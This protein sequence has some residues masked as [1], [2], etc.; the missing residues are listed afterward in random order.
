FK[1][2]LE[3]H[4]RT[5][6]ELRAIAADYPGEEDW[7]QLKRSIS[8]ILSHAPTPGK[9]PSSG[10]WRVIVLP[11]SSDFNPL[12]QR[13]LSYLVTLLIPQHPNEQQ[14]LISKLD[15]AYAN[16]DRHAVR[17]G[18]PNVCRAVMVH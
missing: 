9:H 4:G 5:G 10:L 2:G 14:N 13:Y 16:A 12:S 6:L 17:V 18:D 3:A 8:H 11:I 7:A 1:S 15:Q